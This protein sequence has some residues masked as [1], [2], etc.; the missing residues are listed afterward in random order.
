MTETESVVDD[1]IT[2][3]PN[4]REEIV[5]AIEE[6]ESQTASVESD[7]VS[8]GYAAPTTEAFNPDIHESDDKGNPRL[9]KDGRFRKKRGQKSNK[10]RNNQGDSVNEANTGAGETNTSQPI[11]Y[12]VTAVFFT[13]IVFSTMETAFGK[14][15]KPSEA[16]QGN[17]NYCATRFCEANDITDLPPGIALALAFGMYAL[18]RLND[19]ETKERMRSYG[20]SLGLVSPRKKVTNMAE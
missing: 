19:P 20:E 2:N 15:W 6:K 3:E 9:T 13:T 17:I 8:V 18:P 1:I 11:D 12:K 10:N 4:V 7:P 16:E 5:N 14:A